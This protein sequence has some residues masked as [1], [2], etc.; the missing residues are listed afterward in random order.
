MRLVLYCTR[1]AARMH[2]Y[3]AVADSLASGC[4]SEDADVSAKREVVALIMLA[5]H[6]NLGSAAMA[7]CALAH[8]PQGAQQVRRLERECHCKRNAHFVLTSGFDRL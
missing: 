4:C 7:L 3:G 8:I 5:S 1:S 6:A 2:V